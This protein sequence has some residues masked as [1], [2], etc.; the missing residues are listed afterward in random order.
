MARKVEVHPYDPAWP[1]MYKEEAARLRPVI[2]ME[3]I[4]GEDRAERFSIARSTGPAGRYTAIIPLRAST[5]AP[6]TTSQLK[7]CTS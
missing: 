6:S 2:G 5:I 4:F 3:C 1:G 7:A